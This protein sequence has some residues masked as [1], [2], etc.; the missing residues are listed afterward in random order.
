MTLPI[1]VQNPG[2]PGV[3]GSPFGAVQTV[4]LAASGTK[5]LG[6]GT[7]QVVTGAHDTVIINTSVSTSL[8]LVPASAAGMVVSDGQNVEILADVTG[9]TTTSFY[10]ILGT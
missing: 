3:F 2:Y 4:T 1:T 10:Q 5:V 9:G 7:W 6:P 8:T